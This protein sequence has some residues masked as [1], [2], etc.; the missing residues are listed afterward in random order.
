[1]KKQYLFLLPA[2]MLSFT[3]AGLGFRSYL[4]LFA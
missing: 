1:M 3:Y 4:G 2:L